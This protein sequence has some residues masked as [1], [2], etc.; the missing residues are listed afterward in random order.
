MVSKTEV[1]VDIYIKRNGKQ[2]LAP[3][4]IC[5]LREIHKGGSLRTA[6][7]EL[8]ISYQNMWET[9]DELNN[10]AAQVVVVKQRGGLGGGGAVLTEYGKRLLKEFSLIENEVQ[11]FIDRLNT[12]INL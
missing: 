8:N 2:L 12:E 1:A 6:A 3:G 4:K 10:T 9:I 5:L 11:K 7:K